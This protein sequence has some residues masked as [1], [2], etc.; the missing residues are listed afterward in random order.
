MGNAISGFLADLIMEELEVYI[1]NR[2]P[3]IV[4][5]YRRFVD[6]ILA[7]VPNGSKWYRKQLSSARYWNFNGHNPMTHKRNVANAITDRAITFTKP[8]D[9]H[10]IG[11][12]KKLLQD[13]GY[14]DAF[15]ENVYH[16]IIM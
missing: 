12:I 4:P 14:S 8:E 3:F 9:H 11:T 7:F 10:S 2:L 1:L 16:R 6:Y 13:N 5:F 15:V